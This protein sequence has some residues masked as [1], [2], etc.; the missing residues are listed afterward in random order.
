M[1]WQDLPLFIKDSFDKNK[2]GLATYKVSSSWRS[3]DFVP[4]S[5]NISPS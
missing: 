3:F 1:F 4:P 5:C 2:L